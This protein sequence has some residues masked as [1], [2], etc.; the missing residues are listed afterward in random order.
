MA[1]AAGTGDRVVAAAATAEARVRSPMSFELR[2]FAND[3]QAATV[4]SR[5]AMATA[6]SKA[7][8]AG[9]CHA[10]DTNRSEVTCDHR[11]RFYESHANRLSFCC[12]GGHA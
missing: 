1:A 5:E 4:A 2:R 6:S 3:I 10:F 9:R 11:R 7:V 8:A 12:S